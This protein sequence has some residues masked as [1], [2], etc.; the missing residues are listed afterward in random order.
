[1]AT[2]FGRTKLGGGTLF[3][4]GSNSYSGATL[5]SEGV[6]RIANSLALGDVAGTTT[7]SSGAALEVLGDIS[8]EGE[9]LTLN[10]SG[11]SSQ[12]AL[13]NI[14]GNNSFSGPIL[15]GSDVRIQSDS[16]RL[17]LS[18]GI[19]GPTFGLIFG[20]S[21]SFLVSG[22]I[23]TTTG[24]LTKEGSGILILAGLNSY[25]G[26]T[27]I[28]AGSL[29]IGD[30]GTTGALYPSTASI[31]GIVNNGTLV[32]NRSDTITQGVDFAK[33]LTGT[34]S[35]LKL[36]AGTVVLNGKFTTQ[37]VGGTPYRTILGDV[38]VAAGTLQIDQ[39]SNLFYAVDDYPQQ[40][41]RLAGHLDVAS[42]ANFQVTSSGG[43]TTALTLRG[44]VT[45]AGQ[46]EVRDGATLTIDGNASGFTG[47]F[48]LAMNGG[49]ANLELKPD[50]SSGS[51]QAST[52][53][54][55]VVLNTV[56]SE[57]NLT[58]AAGANI[59]LNGAISGL[60]SVYQGYGSSGIATLA[61]AN[62]YTGST[63]ITAGTLQA[64]S[65]ALADTSSI[66]VSGGSLRAVN[67][68]PSAQLWVYNAA[69]AS[70]SGS[71][72]SLGEM[73]NESSAA[74]GLSFSAGTGTITLGS[75]QGTGVT[76]FASNATVTGWVDQGTLSVAGLLTANIRNGEKVSMISDGD[77]G[78]IVEMVSDGDGGFV[79]KTV[80]L[81]PI[82]TAAS[83]VSGTISGGSIT[84]IGAGRTSTVDLL[85]GGT[86]QLNA[87][88]LSV[89]SSGLSGAASVSV[90]NGTTLNFTPVSAATLSVEKLSL[91]TGG[92]I[93]MAWGS[94]IT[95]SGAATLSGGAF[96]LNLSGSY[97]SGQTYTLIE[98][99][100]GSSLLG[101]YSLLGA[102]GATPTWNITAGRVQVSFPNLLP[103]LYWRGGL[104]PDAGKVWSTTNW[105]TDASGTTPSAQTPSST[106]TVYLS[107]DNA[108][109]ANQ[110]GMTLGA[111][112][113]VLGISVTS[114]NPSTLLIDG[115]T[116]TTGSSGISMAV[117]AGSF[118]IAPAMALAADQT[119]V[120]DSAS[121]LTVSGSLANAGHALVITGSGKTVVSGVISGAGS[122][123][124][125]GTG[126]LALTGTNTYTGATTV[127]AGSLT[128]TSGAFGN[129]SAL[130]ITAA[131]VQA[132]NL[133]HD[134][135]L[136]VASG[137]VA[138]FSGSGLNLGTVS[139]SGNLEFSSLIGVGSLSSLAGAS[140]GVTTFR[141]SGFISS[142]ST[143]GLTHV[144]GGTLT[145]H[146]TVGSVGGFT[147]DSGAWAQFEKTGRLG[148]VIANG[149][150]TVKTNSY[151]DSLQGNGVVTSNGSLALGG[152][153]YT[154]ALQVPETLSKQ[155]P[156]TL[157][158]GSSGH[159]IPTT[160]VESGSM[161]LSATNVLAT[162]GS[163]LVQGSATFGVITG[164]TQTLQKV[165]IEDGATIGIPGYAGE[166]LA[167]DMTLGSGTYLMTPVKL[168]VGASVEGAAANNGIEGMTVGASKVLSGLGRQLSGSLGNSFETFTF[169][170]SGQAPGSVA[171]LGGT[172][173]TDNL[174]LSAVAGGTLQLQTDFNPSK[175]ST[176]TVGDS[177]S[178]GVVLKV[179]AY[180]GG[181]LTLGGTS[182]SSPVSQVL[183][184]KG[185]IVGDIII[186]SGAVVKP[187]NS[188]GQL[189]VVGNVV[190]M[191]G[192]EL[193]FE[194]TANANTIAGTGPNDSITLTG[195][196]GSA[197]GISAVAYD[198]N[199]K[200]RVNDFNKHTFD[201]ITYTLGT[202]TNGT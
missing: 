189:G 99:G 82:V 22:S 120:N 91:S 57:L 177:S 148:T 15:L 146:A 182:F 166:L 64:V 202:D 161:L 100:V 104:D 67:F 192:S 188:P 39:P 37:T 172:A 117:G 111:D 42:G 34:G 98:G 88:T 85:S 128:A 30:G 51:A 106:Y 40:D 71:N 145:V 16:D 163:L 159:Q 136:S 125:T 43:N 33:Y 56:E 21:G 110:L 50:S 173:F 170:L 141:S 73:K 154:G 72:L 29:Q 79:P 48:S 65:G 109:A 66:E 23:E 14:S 93:A 8:V 49:Y 114:A 190:A 116:L 162:S 137:A 31:G 12:G 143:L 92:T 78:W 96:K 155:G 139:N 132:V 197:G 18:G 184:G 186:G 201:I 94:K 171:Q 63:R 1:M 122:L 131:T 174:V 27:T 157:Y 153:N 151:I 194:Y 158:L 58:P 77:G 152:G 46:I 199:G 179:G 90:G 47:E 135:L 11:I 180:Q 61:G 24:A 45:G 2:T 107:A 113:S 4:S 138:R 41:G 5:V 156:G 95:A 169:N 144:M 75:L 193:Q 105:A 54:A 167:Y 35:I 165:V 187:G 13:R 19:S 103:N 121:A 126:T 102:G 81:P 20:G 10:G 69:R 198:P 36:G 80:A 185:T 119:W 52:F 97:V 195:S 7:V 181:T 160:R 25:S 129:T 175:I 86:V 6:L 38:S 83:V 133:N 76:S 200:P 59:T 74:I 140:S 44:A 28:S 196:L 108:T 87:G 55:P 89:A 149:T 142:L 191:P 147:V 168:R 17:T 176:L 183:K 164:G 178:S 124:M 134:A 70:V 32:F 3:L 130:S 62:T 150:V 60:G 118:S 68:N 115:H 53:N 101:T 127:S 9:T 123:S 112:V 26:L 84:L